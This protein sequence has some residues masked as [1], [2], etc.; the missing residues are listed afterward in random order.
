MLS[1]RHVHLKEEDV[2][3]LFGEAGLT[4]NRYLS[5]NNG[6]WASNEF[7]TLKGPK[8]S[9]EHVRVLGPCRGYNQAEVLQADCYKLG[10][11]APVRNSGHHDGA[12]ELELIGPCGAL[13]IHSAII[14][15]RHIH[16]G[17]ELLEETGWVPGETFVKVHVGGIRGLV[18]EN[19]AIVKGGKG[20][21]MH[22]DVEEGNAAGIKNGDKLE[23]IL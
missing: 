3:A 19:V 16:V 5:G 13:T 10:I 22:V 2:A 14:A 11:K 20:M 7:V 15:H 1:N 8:G 6:P 9:I 18:F 4:F 21:M 12:A 23:I 17:K